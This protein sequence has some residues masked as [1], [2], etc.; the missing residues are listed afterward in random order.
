M[1]TTA[2]ILVETGK[3]LV[4]DEIEIPSLKSGQVLVE[5]KMSGVCHTQLSETRGYRGVDRFLPHCLGHEASGVVLEISPGVTKV[6]PGD[7]VVLSWIKGEGADVSGTSYRWGDKIVNA[8]GITTFSR[9]TVVSENR[10]SKLD[11]RLSFSQGA[12]LGCAIPTG[13][14]AVFNSASARPGQSLMVCGCGGIGLCVIAAARLAGCSPIIGVDQNP[15]KLLSAKEYGADLVINS[16]NEDIESTLR[17][18]VKNGVDIAVDATGSTHVMSSLLSFV[19]PQGGIG[20]V[21]GNAKSGAKIELDPVQLN[22]GKQLRGT[23]GG[24]NTVRTDFP[25]YQALLLGDRVSLAP[26]LKSTYQLEDIN[27][28]INDLEQGK[29]LRPLIQCNS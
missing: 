22:M 24:D 20:V 2:A 16:V 26:M 25:R 5:V 19:S 1:K 15:M 12:L 29:V 21:I 28:A 11:D 18:V 14:G 10:I 17:K 8:G 27:E 9:M 23:W 3:P 6:M 13:F 4:I 7:R